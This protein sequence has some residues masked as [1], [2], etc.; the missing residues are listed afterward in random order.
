LRGLVCVGLGLGAADPHT[1]K[2]QIPVAQL[3]AGVMFIKA[4][5]MEAVAAA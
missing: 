1:P 4:L 3:E 2:E 5:L